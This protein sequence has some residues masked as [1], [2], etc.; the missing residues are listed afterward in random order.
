MT[1]VS[2]CLKNNLIPFGSISLVIIIV[3]DLYRVRFQIQFP[4]PEKQFVL[5]LIELQNVDENIL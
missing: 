1:S 4:F 3:F 2:G 5:L